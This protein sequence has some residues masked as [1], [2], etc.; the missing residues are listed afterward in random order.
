[1]PDH[2][3]RLTT[4]IPMTKNAVCPFCYT[5][6][7]L[8][9]GKKCPN[10]NCYSHLHD[11]PIPLEVFTHKLFPIAIVGASSSGKSHFLAALKHCLVNEGFWGE[12]NENGYWKWSFVEYFN[13]ANKDNTDLDNP[14]ITYEENLY[15]NHRT[16][17]STRR[18]DEHPPMLLSLEYLNPLQRMFNDPLVFKKSLLV[19]ITDTAGEHVQGGSIGALDI[20]YPVLQKMVKGAIVIVDPKE[21]RGEGTVSVNSVLAW[22]KR[23][24]EK[25]RIPIAFCMSKI[26]EL[27]K[28]NET[29]PPDWLDERFNTNID[30][31]G[32]LFLPDIE[33][34]SNA[35]Y[36]WMMGRSFLKPTAEDLKNSFRYHA[37]FATTA[38]GI[39]PF[40]LDWNGKPKVDSS[41]GAFVLKN[42]SP[43]PLRVLDP[44]MWILWQHG[45]LGGTDKIKNSV[46]GGTL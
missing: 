18:D 44:L 13:P 28:G 30:N 1:M 38:L 15:I 10:D 21:A 46:A 26:D 33:N 8:E 4:S 31:I 37:F 7:M 16:L 3:I 22:F 12:G 39:D 14:Y 35:V 36:E 24:N 29:I 17:D 40:A 9:E 45:Q 23:G 32:Q 5:E 27:A 2:F 42:G 11:I 41:G 43:K 20:N 25:S 19:A 6:Q 34:N